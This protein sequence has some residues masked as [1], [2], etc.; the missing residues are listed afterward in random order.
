MFSL[1]YPPSTFETP[2][3]TPLKIKKHTLDYLPETFGTPHYF[4]YR[5]I[6]DMF[7]NFNT[8]AKYIV[9]NIREGGDNGLFNFLFP[10]IL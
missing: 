3:F 1:V 6:P 7:I 2:T 5:F 9:M 8:L 4:T 10:N